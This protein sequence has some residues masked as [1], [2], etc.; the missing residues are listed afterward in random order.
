MIEPPDELLDLIRR[1][2]GLRLRPYLC[3]AGVP[4][5]GYG[6]TGPEVTMRSPPISRS[7]AEAW[8]EEDA[9]R[10]CAMAIR[11]SPALAIDRARLAAIADFVYN[12]GSGRYK[13]STLRRRVDAGDWDDAAEQLGRWVWGGGRKLPGLVTRRAAEA[14]LL[15]R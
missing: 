10:A 8:L 1:F 12:L 15:A 7:L 14:V 5:I 3:P 11:I 4:T 13:A 2:E 6:H 9:A